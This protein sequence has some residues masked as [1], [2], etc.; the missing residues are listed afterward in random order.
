MLQRIGP[1][2]K[3]CL[4]RAARCRQLAQLKTDPDERVGYFALEKI[5]LRLADSYQFSETLNQ[6]VKNAQRGRGVGLIDHFC[7]FLVCA[8]CIHCSFTSGSSPSRPAR[9]Q[10]YQ[11]LL[12]ALRSVQAS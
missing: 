4:L 9:R 11:E 3:E 8:S 1:R 12:M 2:Q 6:F 5:W 7:C 10:H